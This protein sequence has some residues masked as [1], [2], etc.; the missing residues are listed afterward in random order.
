MIVAG[1]AG[2]TAFA[3]I[4]RSTCRNCS[5]PIQLRS[6]IGWTHVERLYVCAI[7]QEEDKPYLVATP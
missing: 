7:P 4:E 2:P 6:I 1:D 3:V 5:Q